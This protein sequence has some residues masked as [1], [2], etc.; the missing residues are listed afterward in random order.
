MEGNESLV[1]IISYINSPL[2][3]S[4][5]GLNIV[6]GILKDSRHN[7]K[8]MLLALIYSILIAG[9]FGAL[10]FNRTNIS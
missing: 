9:F 4:S 7:S 5:S 8:N 3:R 6:A 2:S 1:L 10:Y